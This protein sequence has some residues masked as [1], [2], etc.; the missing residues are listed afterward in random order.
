MSR[1]SFATITGNYFRC[2]EGTSMNAYT[3][4]TL[5]HAFLHF[6]KQI[7]QHSRQS[8]REAPD[9]HARLMSLYPQ[10]NITAIQDFTIPFMFTFSPHFFNS[11]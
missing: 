7:I 4:A 3:I 9:I 11:S 8:L 2:M 1:L 5:V 10:G 6:R